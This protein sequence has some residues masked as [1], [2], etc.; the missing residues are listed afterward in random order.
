[1]HIP[2]EV[3][4]RFHRGCPFLV[5]LG[6]WDNTWPDKSSTILKRKKIFLILWFGSKNYH[7]CIVEGKR[8]WAP[9]SSPS[10]QG[11]CVG[12]WPKN[13]IHLWKC[14]ATAPLWPLMESLTLLIMRWVGHPICGQPKP[15]GC[16]K[17]SPE[18]TMS[19]LATYV[20]NIA[21]GISTRRLDLANPCSRPLATAGLLLGQTVSL[22]VAVGFCC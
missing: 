7:S 3:V 5:C 1:M 20:P 17:S 13:I 15:E 18:M 6:R 16:V 4:R 10:F 12:R 19:L 11:F 2:E 14:L 9:W 22:R 21:I 8:S